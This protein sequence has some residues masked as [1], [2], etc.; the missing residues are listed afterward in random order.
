MLATRGGSTRLISNST[1]K[2][3]T[4]IQ[5]NPHPIDETVLMKLIEKP[6]KINN[7]KTESKTT[8]I[9]LRFNNSTILTN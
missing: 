6:K 8:K 7:E 4:N 9:I 3:D 2:S 5:G 1:K